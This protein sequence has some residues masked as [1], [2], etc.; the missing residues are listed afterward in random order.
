LYPKPA[1]I[2]A[3]VISNAELCEGVRRLRDDDVIPVRVLARARLLGPEVGSGAH[4]ERVTLEIAGESVAAVL[5]VIAPN[6]IC[7]TREKRFYEE[8]R[9]SCARAC[10]VPTRRER[11]PAGATAGF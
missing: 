8:R 9:R 11:S 7:V 5:K 1:A 3:S 10:R 4:F 6:P 2:L